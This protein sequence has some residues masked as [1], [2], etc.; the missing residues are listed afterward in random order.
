MVIDASV[1]AK[2]FLPEPDSEHAIELAVRERLIAPA[3]IF[4]EVANAVWSKREFLAAGEQ[5]SLERFRSSLAEVA[6]DDRLTEGALRIAMELDHP[7]YDCLYLQLAIERGLR[8]V[9]AD[10]KFIARCAGT[11]YR[12]ALLPFADWA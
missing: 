9:T 12:G 1:A 4:S 2:W 6:E 5:L 7:V 11:R 3:L 10:A 8:L